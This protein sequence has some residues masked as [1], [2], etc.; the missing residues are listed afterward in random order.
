M[1]YIIYMVTNMNFKLNSF[2]G[3]IGNMMTFKASSSGTGNIDYNCGDNKI[4]TIVLASSA[5][6][7]V[8]LYSLMKY[9][10]FLTSLKQNI[11]GLGSD[12]DNLFLFS[13]VK[14]L[15]HTVFICPII[16]SCC[17]LFGFPTLHSVLIAISA[18]FTIFFLVALAAKYFFGPFLETNLSF[19]LEVISAILAIAASLLL[20][21][22]PEPAVYVLVIA[23]IFAI[24]AS[25]YFSKSSTP[26]V[27]NKP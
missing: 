24:F 6:V 27:T 23:I 17:F 14:A 2:N 4:A 3:N 15:I 19:Y 8:I 22:I 12:K 7:G 20:N 9:D 26:T 21:I 25:Y 16:L 11:S 18:S 1:I 10:I 5:G 13:A